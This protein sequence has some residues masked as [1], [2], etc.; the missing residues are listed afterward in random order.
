MID[1]FYHE[2]ALIQFV[3]MLLFTLPLTTDIDIGI[4]SSWIFICCT[5]KKI[6]INR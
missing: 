3:E 2:K 5:I 4:I 6:H 1:V